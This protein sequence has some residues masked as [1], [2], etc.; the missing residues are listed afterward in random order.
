[1]PRHQRTDHQ[2]LAAA[3]GLVLSHGPKGWCQLHAT[4]QQRAL[5]RVHA[6]KLAAK[7]VPLA[8]L[9]HLL[10]A[11]PD[12]LC[13]RVG[14]D[15]LMLC[16]WRR[17]VRH[18][19]QRPAEDGQPL[20]DALF[21]LDVQTGV[22]G[23][24]AMDTADKLLERIVHVPVFHQWNGEVDQRVIK[25][26]RCRIVGGTN[27]ADTPAAATIR[28]SGDDTG[29][30]ARVPLVFRD[31]QTFG[32]VPARHDVTNAEA[33]V[34]WNLQ[35]QAWVR[36][37]HVLTLEAA[38]LSEGEKRRQAIADCIAVLAM[39]LVVQH[40]IN[41]IELPDAGRHALVA[42]ARQ[43]LCQYRQ[44]ID[45]GLGL[46]AADHR[47]VVGGLRLGVSFCDLSIGSRKASNFQH[48]V[49]RLVAHDIR[50]RR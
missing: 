18:D 45:E 40:V 48:A 6:L 41:D 24:V 35:I 17:S 27:H 7:L 44:T 26:M 5:H 36:K 28:L 42:I 12:G 21:S 15:G 25:R 8:A 4:A 16:V 3:F 9:R 30:A 37:F 19:V 1:M 22:Q 11:T 31:V 49:V 43:A 20:P 29:L 33:Q 34:L 32:P 38:K 14:Q 2:S 13:F 50:E 46:L 39:P 10:D 23:T 47:R